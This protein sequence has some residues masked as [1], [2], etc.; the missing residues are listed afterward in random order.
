MTRPQPLA[1]HTSIIKRTAENFPKTALASIQLMCLIAKTNQVSNLFLICLVFCML[2]WKF[3]LTLLFPHYLVWSLSSYFTTKALFLGIKVQIS[4]YETLTLLISLFF[5]NKELFKKNFKILYHINFPFYQQNTW[6][7]FL[8]VK[9]QIDKIVRNCSVEKTKVHKNV[10]YFVIIFY[11]LFFLGKRSG[12][13]GFRFDNDWTFRRR[14]TFPSFERSFIFN[15]QIS[16]N[17]NC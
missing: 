1:D 2:L 11:Y 4:M 17:I 3:L 8:A 15:K 10:W 14:E 13:V 7:V 9:N 16:T 6:S 12:S 5:E